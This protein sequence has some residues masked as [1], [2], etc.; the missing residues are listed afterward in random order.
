MTVP[1]IR[2]AFPDGDFITLTGSVFFDTVLVNNQFRVGLFDD[3]NPVTAGDGAGF[4]GIYAGAP[5]LSTGH[6]NLN[7][8]D[9][10]DE[11]PFT[12]GAATV[13]AIMPSVHD[14]IPGSTTIDFSLAMTRNGANLDV[15][16]SFTYDG[17]SRSSL[18]LKD[19]NVA[20]T[21]YDRVSF[22]M[23]NEQNS[24]LATYSNIEVTTGTIPEPSTLVLAM[25]GLIRRGRPKHQ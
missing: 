20:Y 6:A 16:A 21:T 24:T 10:T 12:D 13:L 15:S 1:P 5:A 25:L 18:N 22:F 7:S 2:S 4:V 23:G 17:T 19:R 3:N 9:G 14:P 11:N 8:G